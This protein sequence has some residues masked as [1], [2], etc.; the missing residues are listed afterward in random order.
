L[1]ICTTRSIY[2]DP[3][4][5][6]AAHPPGPPGLNFQ[7]P[8]IKKH[9]KQIVPERTRRIGQ[10][11]LRKDLYGSSRILRDYDRLYVDKHINRFRLSHGKLTGGTL[12]LACAL[13]KETP[14]HIVRN[15]A[16]YRID[17]LW[18]KCGSRSG[19]IW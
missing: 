9:E 3:I 10:Q 2:S 19:A 12:D 14:N 16:L 15:I 17:L 18:T 5:H 8:Q 11:P 4:W 6:S 7:S 1:V 13:F